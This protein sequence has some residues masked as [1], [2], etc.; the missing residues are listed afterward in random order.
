M[1]TLSNNLTSILLIHYKC[2]I[3]RLNYNFIQKNTFQL[4]YGIGTLGQF[5]DIWKSVIWNTK[6]ILM[7][8]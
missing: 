8:L 5:F 1:S 3:K 4:T 2:Y 7:L 6:T